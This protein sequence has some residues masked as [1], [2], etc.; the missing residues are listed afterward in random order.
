MS[1]LNYL[2]LLTFKTYLFQINP[3]N[4]NKVIYQEKAI[5]EEA[6][7]IIQRELQEETYGR[8][9]KIKKSIFEPV[10]GMGSSFPTGNTELRKKYAS[11]SA[12]ELVLAVFSNAKEVFSAD[13][14]RVSLQF[15]QMYQRRVFGKIVV[16]LIDFNLR[17]Y[18]QNTA[19][20]H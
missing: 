10:Q 9:R 11:M 8:L 7:R 17:I 15:F 20:F 16:K 3:Q 19:G 12:A 6:K 14:A 18:G 1:E 13:V 4:L 2:L 5:Q